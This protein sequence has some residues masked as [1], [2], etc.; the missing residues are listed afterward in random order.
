MPLMRCWAATRPKR[1]RRCIRG[2]ESRSSPPA[3]SRPRAMWRGHRTIS[4][5]SGSL[6]PNPRRRCRNLSSPRCCRAWGSSLA[7]TR[8]RMT[9]KLAPRPR[10]ARPLP[11][12]WP[13]LRAP[14]PRPNH[15]GPR[16]TRLGTRTGRPTEWWRPCD[17]PGRE[18]GTRGILSPFASTSSPSLD[19]VRIFAR[20]DYIPTVAAAYGAYGVVAFRSKPTPASQARLQR[21][22]TSFLSALPPRDEGGRHQA[23]P[24]SGWRPFGRWTIPQSHTR[25]TASISLLTTI[26][27]RRADGD[28]RC[29]TAGS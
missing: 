10:Q 27:T 3:R 29:R 1:R 11:R 7:P 15:P 20:S 4:G 22:C 24:G 9:A 21:V 19:A 25:P 16:R 13:Q 14:L 12:H 18:E 28:P 26:S 5:R 2:G 8:P 6:E 23:R 17:P